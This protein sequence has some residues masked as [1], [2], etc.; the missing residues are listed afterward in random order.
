[1]FT[2]NVSYASSGRVDLPVVIWESNGHSHFV[3]VWEL[4]R[5][6]ERM[7]LM[8]GYDACARKAAVVVIA[9][10]KS[11]RTCSRFLAQTTTVSIVP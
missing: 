6:E 2:T 9:S 3:R 8:S 10:S 7:Q 4:M 1:M 11:A 5:S